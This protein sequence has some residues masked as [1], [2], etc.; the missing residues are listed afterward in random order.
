MVP[1]AKFVMDDFPPG[2]NNRRTLNPNE[3]AANSHI[4]VRFFKLSS[5]GTRPA[6][7]SRPGSNVNGIVTVRPSY[8]KPRGI[9]PRAKWPQ[10]SSMGAL[11]GVAGGE[12]RALAAEGSEIGGEDIFK[13]LVVRDT[14]RA[15]S[16][17]ELETS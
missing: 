3:M 4:S 2:P 9:L 5:I 1:P 8:E 16:L 7:A 17:A 12:L 10:P 11:L 6:S 13:E 15:D 14:R